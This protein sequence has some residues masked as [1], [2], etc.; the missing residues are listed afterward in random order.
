MRREDCVSASIRRPRNGGSGVEE[1]RM[2][3]HE[4]SPDIHRS[5]IGSFWGIPKT[6]AIVRVLDFAFGR[7]KN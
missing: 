6:E 1:S 5:V 3:M 4:D 2:K 7:S